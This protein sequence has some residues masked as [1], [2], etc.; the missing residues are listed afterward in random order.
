MDKFFHTVKPMGMDGGFIWFNFGVNEIVV[1][2]VECTCD[3]AELGK[4]G[5]NPKKETTY[6]S[7]T[8]LFFVFFFNVFSALSLNTGSIH[9]TH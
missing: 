2:A 5:K 1:F 9:K 4:G 3:V 7:N 8:P 6:P